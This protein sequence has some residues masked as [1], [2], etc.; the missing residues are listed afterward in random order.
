MDP[1]RLSAL[2]K[3]PLFHGLTPTQIATIGSLLESKTVRLGTAVIKEGSRG[4]R[5]F[6]IES[7]KASVTKQGKR[8]AVL[9]PGDHFGELALLDTVPRRAT[10]IAMT[11]LSLLAIDRAEF[12]G[13]LGR[14]PD[15]AIALLKSAARRLRE[16]QESLVD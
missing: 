4:S 5:F 10:V 15:L 7:G 13:L 12:L 11:D 2:K 3:V 1:S 14:I 9:G 8:I 16:N 6:I